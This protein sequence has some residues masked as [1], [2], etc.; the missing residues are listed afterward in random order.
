[1]ILNSSRGLGYK[2]DAPDARDHVYGK[3]GAPLSGSILREPDVSAYIGRVRDQGATSS[4]VGQALAAALEI[5]SAVRGEP[6]NLS[7]SWIYQVARERERPN[8]R[9]PL[10]DDGSYPKNALE[11]AKARGIL[12]EKNHPFDVEA[13]NKRP[14][15][16]DAHLAYDARGLAYAQIE[17]TGEARIE[18]LSDALR[19]GFGVLFGMDI[20]AAYMRS[21]GDVVKGMGA[22]SGGHMQCV[23]A[24]TDSTVRV[25][26]SWSTS[27]GDRGLVDFDR[28]FFADAALSSLMVVREVPLAQPLLPREPLR[29][30]RLPRRAL[31]RRRSRRVQGPRRPEQPHPHVMLARV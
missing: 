29:R 2:P 8:Y 26:N 19:R 31:R 24:V 6:R 30:A 1:M 14:S 10:Q 20:D 3:T 23:L 5:H 27:W 15:P 17:A 4:C 22:P 13:I 18:Q 25:L 21:E 11:A 28:A 12:A 9:G 7:A 16:A